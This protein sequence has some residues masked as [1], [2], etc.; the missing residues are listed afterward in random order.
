[1]LPP[2]AC[3]QID[4]GEA[5]ARQL[6]RDVHRAGERRKA[7]Q[8]PRPEWGAGTPRGRARRQGARFPRPHRRVREA[9][10]LISPTSAV[11]CDRRFAPPSG[12]RG[13]GGVGFARRATRASDERRAQRVARL[14]SEAMPSGRLMPGRGLRQRDPS[15]RRAEGMAGGGTCERSERI[16]PPAMPGSEERVARWSA[17][18]SPAPASGGRLSCLQPAPDAPGARS[19][20]RDGAL[21][22]K[23]TPPAPRPPG[24][25]LWEAVATRSLFRTPP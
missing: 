20:W 4:G 9:N 14:V 18:A 15:Q 13:A 3:M 19:G 23:P 16:V 7:A 17:G 8:C 1:M 5:W 10:A 22:A 21:R 24:R 12:R 2:S 25:L 11:T 6:D